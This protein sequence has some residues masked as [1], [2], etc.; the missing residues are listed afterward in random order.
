MIKL[1]PRQ[2]HLWYV[3]FTDI[4]DQNLLSQYE[5]LLSYDERYQMQRYMFIDDK[6]RFLITRALVRTTLSRYQS[7][8][9]QEW[10]FSKN[11]YG[12]PIINNLVLQK[13]R[14]S[15]N[16]SHTRD[17]I[18]LGITCEHE[19]GV[20]VENIHQVPPYEIMDQFFSPAETLTIQKLP[21]NR[22][23]EYFFKH[24]TLK[25][26]YL[27]ARG[28]GL[29]VPLDLVSFLVQKKKIHVFIDSQLRDKAQNWKFWQFQ[30]SPQHIA[31]ICISSSAFKN[32]SIITRNIIPLDKEEIVDCQ[33]IMSH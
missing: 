3:F 9:P 22:Q 11:H 1:D 5:G 33:F 26:C 28:V 4:K 17:L 14:I 16:V 30:P 31:S 18:L 20:D 24:W 21:V 27:K 29:S 32:Q 10:Y 23:A 13:Q 8:L 25:E 15:F 2:I 12:K 7:I 6:L 19:V